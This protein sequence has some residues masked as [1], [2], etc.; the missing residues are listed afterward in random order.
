MLLL[1]LL[2]IV[3]LLLPVVLVEVFQLLQRLLECDETAARAM[4]KVRAP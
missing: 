4:H 3:L 2:L 1:L